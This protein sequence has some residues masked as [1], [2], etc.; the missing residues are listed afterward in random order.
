MAKTARYTGDKLQIFAET[1]AVVESKYKIDKSDETTLEIQTHPRWFTPEGLA[2]ND[3]GDV[4][5]LQD[6]SLNIAMV[7]Q[8]VPDGN[9][10][11]VKVT[12]VIGRYNRGIPKPETVKETDASLP[13]WVEDRTN[14]LALDI[15]NKLPKY[16]VQTVPGQVAP[17]AAPQTPGPAEGSATPAAAP[18]PGAAQ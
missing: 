14:T 13:G 16:Q 10:Y 9:D 18:A 3:N 4:S 5:T 1:R 11:L 17:A 8:L 6:R 15:H 12:P 7:V 2:A